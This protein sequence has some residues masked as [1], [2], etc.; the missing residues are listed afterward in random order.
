MAVSAETWRVHY[1]GFGPEAAENVGVDCI[2]RPFTGPSGHSAGEAVVVDVNGRSSPEKIRLRRPRTSG[3]CATTASGRSTIRRSASTASSPPRSR[4]LP[5]PRPRP[6]PPPRPPRRRSPPSR[7]RPRS[8]P[9]PHPR[10]P[11]H[12]R[13]R[14][15]IEG[16]GVPSCG[17]A[18]SAPCTGP[19][20]H[21][22]RS[23]P[24]APA[25][26]TPCG[27]THLAA[28]HHGLAQR[29]VGFSPYP[30]VEVV[31]GP[32]HGE[33]RRPDVPTRPSTARIR[34]VSSRGRGG[35]MMWSA[36]RPRGPGTASSSSWRAVTMITGTDEDRPDPPVHRQSL[37][38]AELQSSRI[39]R[40]VGRAPPGPRLRCRRPR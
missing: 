15:P 23:T 18:R 34:A 26:R 13:A 7:R 9:R 31:R 10:R 35:L 19:G 40:G 14:A 16:A 32:D 8:P 30:G 27:T 17:P 12:P 6:L 5:H 20:D 1:D 22:A 29:Q 37:E 21:V 4:P 3:S 38:V 25:G 33:S 24:A 39:S 28:A 36:R 11:R 2:R